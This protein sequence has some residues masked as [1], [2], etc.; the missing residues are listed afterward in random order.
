[1]QSSSAAPEDSEPDSQECNV[2]LA[3]DPVIDSQISTPDAA[4]SASFSLADVPQAKVTPIA[5]AIRCYS[6]HR[7]HASECAFSAEEEVVMGQ[8]SGE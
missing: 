2:G 3:L 5:D 8:L 6:V 7:N 4:A 1:M